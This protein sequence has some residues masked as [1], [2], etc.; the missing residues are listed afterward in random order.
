MYTHF[1]FVGFAVTVGFT[2]VFAASCSNTAG[3]CEKTGTC[4]VANAGGSSAGGNGGDAGAGNGGENVGGTSKGGTSGTSTVATC[5]TSKSPS[6]E[7]CLVADKYSVFVSPDGDDADAGT[8]AAPVKTITKALALAATK[9]VVIACSGTYTDAVSITTRAKVYGSFD[10]LNDWKYD[11]SKPSIIAP[12]T[13]TPALSVISVPA[14]V[15]LEDIQFK[16]LDATVASGSSIAAFVKESTNVTLH[17]VTLTAGNGSAG[18]TPAFSPYTFADVSTLAG[19][20]GTV[21]AGGTGTLCSCPNGVGSRRGAGGGQ[22]QSGGPGTPT[23]DTASGLGGD[24]AKDCSLG[25]SGL[26]GADAP[27]AELG[28]GANSYGTFANDNWTPAVGKA[29]QDGQPGQGGGGGAGKSAGGGGSGACGGCGGKGGSPGNGG[30]AS[31][32]LLSVNSIVSLKATTLVTGNGG[33]GTDGTIGQSGQEGGFKGRGFGNTTTAGCDGGNG[34]V[35]AAGAAGGGG[36]GGLSVGILYSGTAPTVDSNSTTTLGQPG[37]GGKGG[38][39]AATTDDGIDG[40]AANVLAI[41]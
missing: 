33:K 18:E 11:K 35:G 26:L 20:A 19:N 36:V 2:A 41:P 10:C 34:G 23:Y 38:N 9:K 31:I 3:Q 7:G 27:A 1:R 12:T 28:I 14:I 37:I 40:T 22:L 24:T 13:V 32:A 5:D 15:V 39:N 16:A 4:P 29:G 25:G 6:E 21:D 30:G 8:K 17:R